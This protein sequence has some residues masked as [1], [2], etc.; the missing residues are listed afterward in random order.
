MTSFD[1]ETIIQTLARHDVDYVVIGAMA[2]V[3]QGRAL[4]MTLDVD[5]TAAADAGNLTRLAAALQDMDARL[6]TSPGEEPLAVPLEARML[7]RVSVM[8]FVTRY[9][10]FDVLFDPIGAPPYEELRSRA[11]VIHRFGVAIR[12]ASLDD[13]V[14]MKSA[15]G[16]EKDAAHV[17]QLLDYLNEKKEDAS[18]PP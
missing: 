5:V 6:R 4:P 2:V 15:T 9:G 14:R 17:L 12:V 18:D 11:K 3:M 1:P 13:V 8:T 16:R 10:P 7:S